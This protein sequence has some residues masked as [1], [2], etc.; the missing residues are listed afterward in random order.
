MSFSNNDQLKEY[1]L[2]G[3]LELH[4]MAL[5]EMKA[6]I[7][8]LEKTKQSIANFISKGLKRDLGCI[9]LMRHSAPLEVVF[10]KS[11]LLKESKLSFKSIFSVGTKASK[12]TKFNEL[13][14]NII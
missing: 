10:V 13:N 9:S 1:G 2:K 3:E 6:K 11:D 12:P 14:L 5:D 4:F 7:E 8:N